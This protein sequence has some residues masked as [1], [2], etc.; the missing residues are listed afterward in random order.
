MLLGTSINEM[1]IANMRLNV[2]GMQFTTKQGNK[3][4]LQSIS[5][6]FVPEDQVAKTTYRNNWQ[7]CGPKEYFPV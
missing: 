1:D 5:I 3:I 4:F 2:S 7:S 6:L